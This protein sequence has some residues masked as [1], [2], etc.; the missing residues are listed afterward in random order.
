MGVCCLIKRFRKGSGGQEE[1]KIRCIR[2]LLPH[3]FILAHN[4]EHCCR[5]TPIAGLG[6][7]RLQG[8]AI[9]GNTKAPSIVFSVIAAVPPCTFVHEQCCR[10]NFDSY[11]QPLR[12]LYALLMVSQGRN[13]SGYSYRRHKVTYTTV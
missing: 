4:F 3:L 7:R 11:L 12:P 9:Y 8:I 5:H 6:R 10:R 2:G 1:R 13:K